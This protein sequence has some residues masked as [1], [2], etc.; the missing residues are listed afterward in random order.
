MSDHSISAQ[1][2]DAAAKPVVKAA[3]IIIGDEILS[4]R[5]KDANL[6][7]LAKWL[8]GEGIR[9]DEVRV[10]PDDT[11]RIVDHVNSCRRQFD[12]VFTTGGIGPTHDDITAESIAQA[13]AVP[14]HFHPE[15]MALL[16][17]HYPPGEF[18][19]ARQRMARV[20]KGGSLIDN[21]VSVAPGFQIENV[22]VLA[23]VPLIMQSMLESIRHKLVGGLPMLSASLSVPVPESA[24]AGDLGLIA[25]A[26]PDVQIG[27]YPYYREGRAG[28]HVVVRALDQA[29]IDRALHEIE[30]AVRRFG[31]E[32]VRD[33]REG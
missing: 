24:L 32:P 18:T 29:L 28:L 26:H 30:A 22:F 31:A 5:T 33:P 12:Y 27:S 19:E 25:K 2:D 15:A 23:G 4:G 10:I 20:P 1:P 21:P 14:L 13:F 7:Y 3:L 17:A 16:E 6:A 11:S 9:L 8:N